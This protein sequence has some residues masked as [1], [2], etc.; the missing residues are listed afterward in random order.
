[1]VFH[2]VLGPNIFNIF[3]SNGGPGSK[4]GLMKFKG[5]YKAGNITNMGNALPEDLDNVLDW[6]IRNDMKYEIMHS[7]TFNKSFSYKMGDSWNG[8][9]EGI[10]GPEYTD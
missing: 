4:S 7:E 2:R 1:M 8:G 3:I 10:E 5:R 6:S 9:N